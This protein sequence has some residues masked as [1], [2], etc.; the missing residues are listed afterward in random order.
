MWLRNVHGDAQL[1]GSWSWLPSPQTVPWVFH[2]PTWQ[3]WHHWQINLLSTICWRI[4]G[5]PTSVISTRD[6]W[7]VCQPLVSTFLN[8]LL[9][10]IQLICWLSSTDVLL[11]LFWQAHNWP[12]T[13]FYQSSA[14]THGSPR[15]SPPQHK[16]YHKKLIKSFTSMP[17]AI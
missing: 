6:T 13:H 15:A 10:K 12:R 5:Q 1:G 16:Q 4:Y 8:H 2:F 3:Q 14:E 7:E 17:R 11:C 9:P